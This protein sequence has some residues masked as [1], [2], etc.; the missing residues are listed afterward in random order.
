MPALIIFSV[1]FIIPMIISVFF[2]MTVWSFVDFR[3]IGLQNYQMF[4]EDSQLLQGLTNTWIYAV[5]TSMSKVVLALFIA[6][7]LTSNIRLRG[8]LRSIS[9]I[10]TFSPF[11]N[12]SR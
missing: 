4:F 3:F 10:E 6:V 1:L 7:F 12:N 8:M 9:S 5:S 11:P 2:S